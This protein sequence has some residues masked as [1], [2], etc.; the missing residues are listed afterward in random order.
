MSNYKQTPGWIGAIRSGN[1]EQAEAELTQASAQRVQAQ[2]E[3]RRALEGVARV[4]QEL[5]EY[6]RYCT[7]PVVETLTQEV[8]NGRISSADQF[9]SRYRSEMAEEIGRFENAVQPGYKRDTY[10]GYT[11]ADKEVSAYCAQRRAQSDALK[12]EGRA[13]ASVTPNSG[14]RR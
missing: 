3:E 8:A 7:L 12:A 10:N 2:I 13:I 1:F 9:I 5:G 14:T 11:P 6:S 4:N